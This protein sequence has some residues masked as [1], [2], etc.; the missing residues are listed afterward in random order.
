MAIKQNNLA[1][2]KWIEKTT[3][4]Y[5]WGCGEDGTGKNIDGD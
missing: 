5:Y 2:T 3:K 4:D 1:H